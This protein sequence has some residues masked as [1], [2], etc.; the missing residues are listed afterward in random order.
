MSREDVLLKEYEVC[1]QHINALGNQAWQ[2][3][4]I[5]L[6]VNVGILAFMFNREKHDMD[7]LLLTLVI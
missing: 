6:T 3:S 1:Q 7:S 5:F 4:T 2:A